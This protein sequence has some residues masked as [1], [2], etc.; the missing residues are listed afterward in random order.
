MAEVVHRIGMLFHPRDQQVEGQ[1]AQVRV[2]PTLG[3]V[4]ELLEADHPEFRPDD[5]VVEVGDR[6]A[7]LV[8]LQV[9]ARTIEELRTRAPRGT[10]EGDPAGVGD[11]VDDRAP[12]DHGGGGTGAAFDVDD[13]AG[14]Q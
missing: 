6:P 1:A 14:A 7:E 13:S 8:G 12:A 9:A 5:R 4:A 3:L 10:A 2:F 11:R